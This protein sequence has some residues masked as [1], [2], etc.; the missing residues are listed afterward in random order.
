M[1]IIHIQKNGLSKALNAATE[2]LQQGG[3]VAYPTET[4]YGLGAKFDLKNPVERIFLLKNR[5]FNNPLPLIIGN[6]NLLT[7]ITDTPNRHAL[8]LIRNFWPGPL[9]LLL[10]AKR[11]LPVLITGDSGKVGVR[12][13]GQSFAL[14]LAQHANFPITSTSANISGKPP[15]QDAEAVHRSFVDAIDLLID[16]GT[17]VGGYP[18]TIVDACGDTLSIVREGAISSDEINRAV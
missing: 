11:G 2:I 10:P 9:T 7:L 12:I 3:I 6:Q 4:F 18:S 1:N 14:E 17:T 15:A 16:G 5:P 13:P 8:S